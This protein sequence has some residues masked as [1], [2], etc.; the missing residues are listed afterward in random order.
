MQIIL[1]FNDDIIFENSCF[2]DGEALDP[3][4]ISLDDARTFS[5]LYEKIKHFL[6]IFH[7]CSLQVTGNLYLQISLSSDCV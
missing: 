3:R 6:K 1:K 2:Q 5:T 7:I 4:I